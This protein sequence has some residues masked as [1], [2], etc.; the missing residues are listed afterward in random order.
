[1]AWTKYVPQKNWRDSI[2]SAEI[3][4]VGAYADCLLQTRLEDDL[5]T[6]A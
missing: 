6:G 2:F 1:M 4:V 5:Y 3:R